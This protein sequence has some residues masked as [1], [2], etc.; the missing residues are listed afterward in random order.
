MQRARRGKYMKKAKGDELRREYHRDELGRG[1][2]GK[3]YESYSSG[4]NLVLLSPDVAASFP[5][6]KSVNDALR[7]LVKLA[8]QT[9]RTARHAKG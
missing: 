7:S 6:E 3:H 4:T 5:D 1:V 9:A 2:R 8:H